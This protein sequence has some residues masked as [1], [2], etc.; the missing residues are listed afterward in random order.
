MLQCGFQKKRISY[1]REMCFCYG[2]WHAVRRCIILKLNLREIGTELSED[3]DVSETKVISAFYSCKW[4]SE[5]FP[6]V[7]CFYNS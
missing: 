6:A 2:R 4:C 3:V 5:I 7:S 1:V